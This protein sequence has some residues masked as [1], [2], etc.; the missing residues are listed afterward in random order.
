MLVSI[1]SAC[2]YPQAKV[3][4][5]IDASPKAW[6]D[7]PINGSILALG[8]P[9][10][11]VFHIADLGGVNGGELSINDQVLA[12][13]P[14][15]DGTNSPATLR[16]SWTPDKPG[17]YTVR[18]RAQSASGWGDYDQAV[19]TVLEDTPTTTATF[20]PTV[21]LTETPTLTPSP[22]ETVTPTPTMA[23]ITFDRQVSANQFFYGACSPDPLTVQVQVNN[24]SDVYSVI[25]F[26]KLPGQSWNDGTAM[27][28]LG[29]GLFRKKFSGNTVPGHEGVE[30]AIWA[31]QLV[32]TNK[33][34][35]V[36][37]RS[38]AYTDVTLSKCGSPFIPFLPPDLHLITPSATFFIIK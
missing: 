12:L 36:I 27:D 6:I 33:A 30:N 19:V 3:Q 35:K 32:A 18:V 37:A 28:P 11:V 16:Q 5:P 20:T 7:A 8:E 23:G 29:N 31:H 21:T 9:Y 26:Q 24:T 10:E 22:T 14:N 25:L 1:L 15:P 4:L 34:G 17:K 2:N 38:D 13:L